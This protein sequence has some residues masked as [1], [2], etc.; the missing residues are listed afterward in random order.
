MDIRVGRIRYRSF[1]YIGRIKVK[2]NGGEAEVEDKSREQG[3]GGGGTA[4]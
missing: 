3:S 2:L 1:A 4:Q